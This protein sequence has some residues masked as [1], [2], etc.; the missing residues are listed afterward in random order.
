M[1][2][3]SS[4]GGEF[5]GDVELVEALILRLVRL[6]GRNE[7]LLNRKAAGKPL[8]EGAKEENG[9]LVTRLLEGFG[10]CIRSRGFESFCIIFKSLV[11]YSLLFPFFVAL[12]MLHFIFP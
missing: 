5:K 7:F 2:S 8:L 9:V 1:A 4:P 6:Y 12:Q 11:F 3:A 10:N